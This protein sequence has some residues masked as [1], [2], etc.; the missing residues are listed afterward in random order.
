MYEELSREIG[1]I[2]MAIP[3]AR[4][5]ASEGCKCRSQNKE[6]ERETE[7][8]RML[9]TK[10]ESFLLKT[11]LAFVLSLGNFVIYLADAKF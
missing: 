8:E 6:Q 9:S 11:C 3:R 7:T 5:P 2:P 10:P 1:S 4:R